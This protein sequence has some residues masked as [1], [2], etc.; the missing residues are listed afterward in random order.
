MQVTFHPTEAWSYC[1]ER[2]RLQGK[3][4]RVRT[5]VSV[6]PCSLAF[7]ASWW[8][9]LHGITGLSRCPKQQKKW[10]H[11]KERFTPKHSLPSLFLPVEQHRSHGYVSLKHEEF[12]THVTDS[13]CLEAPLELNSVFENAVRCLPKRTVQFGLEVHLGIPQSQIKWVLTYGGSWCVGLD[14]LS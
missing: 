4:Y 13:S 11:C 14:V 9:Q 7:K 6:H 2:H 8:S 10:R 12:P 1:L 5:F 3:Q